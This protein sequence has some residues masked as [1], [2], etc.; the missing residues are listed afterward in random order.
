M[1]GLRSV[2]SRVKWSRGWHTWFGGLPP[3][4]PAAC[5]PQCDSE[6]LKKTSCDMTFG[7]T[8]RIKM[9]SGCMYQP[10]W[11]RQIAK[12]N[13][14]P[15]RQGKGLCDNHSYDNINQ[16]LGIQLIPRYTLLVY[17]RQ[18]SL[19]KTA[20]ARCRD[21][22]TELRGRWSCGAPHSIPGICTDYHRHHTLCGMW[23]HLKHQKR[24]HTKIA[25]SHWQWTINI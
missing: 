2:N 9:S 25:C 21:G 24:F 23:L 4:C 7:V 1:T 11:W 12:S 10:L 16:H 19:V 8:H 22:A 20:A 5:Q 18:N 6:T 14:Q 3:K 13:N 15:D 17:Q